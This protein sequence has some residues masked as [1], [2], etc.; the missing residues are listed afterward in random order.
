MEL[1]FSTDIIEKLL[2][3]QAISNKHWLNIFSNKY[4]KRWFKVPHVGLLLK[5]TLKYYEKYN[6]CPSTKVIQL[7]AKKYSEGHPEENIKLSEVTELLTDISNLNYNI[8][9]DVLNNNFVEFVKRNAF[10]STFFDT[11]EILDRNPESYEKVAD[12]CLANFEQVQ[13][14]IFN[15]TDIGLNYFDPKAME[16][17]WNVIRN[18][19]AKIKLGW[20]G[21][22]TYTNGGVLKD[23]KMLFLLM[24]QAG[25]GKSAFMS[26]LAVNFLKQNLRVV[27]IS[28]EMSQDVYAQRFDAH[29]SE[30]NI[31]KLRENEKTAVERIK[32]F[33]KKYP[34]SS[35]YIKEYPPRSI[36]SN[37]IQA[38]LEN[39]KNT[40]H[41]FDVV[42]VDYLNLVLPNHKTDSMYKD[43]LSVSE[44]LR[45]L[46][47][48]F[49]VPI[50]SAVQSNSE[51]MN[52]DTI[53]M[54]NVAESRG[55]VHTADFLAALM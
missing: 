29:I 12:K 17:H 50:I 16:E 18:P 24:A 49:K 22:D 25:L 30:K 2:F 7:L 42:I 21:L 48:Q 36:R 41:D 54:Q 55:I 39:L 13:K 5:L 37:D 23:G 27:V 14:I 45:A 9:E 28:L 26:N 53:D 34:Q 51:G 4:D 38:Y 19:E 1:D 40:G 44:E 15:D 32:E 3:K 33:Y 47:Y 35:L 8:A 46:S 52:S 31:N 6:A 10:Y 11:I 20:D 43:G